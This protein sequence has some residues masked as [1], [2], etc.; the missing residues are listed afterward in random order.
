MSGTNN[1]HQIKRQNV[2]QSGAGFTQYNKLC[3]TIIVRS[4]ASLSVVSSPLMRVY[5]LSYNCRNSLLTL[6]YDSPKINLRPKKIPVL[7]VA[8][9]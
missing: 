3:P 1:V 9:W 4:T 2:S 7:P 8:G 5:D 6:S